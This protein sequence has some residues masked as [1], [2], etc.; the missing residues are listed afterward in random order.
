[1]TGRIANKVSSAVG[2]RL[3]S[4]LLVVGGLAGIG[5]VMWAEATVRVHVAFFGVAIL[6]LAGAFG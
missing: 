3:I 1:M 5:L 4:A 6:L 2:I